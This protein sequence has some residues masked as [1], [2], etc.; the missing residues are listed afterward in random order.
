MK[1]S[2]PMKNIRKR[3]T[4]AM[5]AAA[6][7]LAM[8][9]NVPTGSSMPDAMLTA[10]AAVKTQ[11]E[12]YPGSNL[13]NQNYQKWSNPIDSYLTVSADGGFMRFQN[14][15]IDGKYLVEYYD[16]AYNI[17][18]VRKIDA[19]LPVFGGFYETETYYF[20]LTGQ[21]NPDELAET[22]CFRITKYDKDWNRLDS[23]GLYDCNTTIPFD[24]GS[25]RFAVCGN[26]LLIRTCHEMYADGNGLNHQANVTIQLD[27]DS[28]EITDSLTEVSNRNHGYISHSFNQF[29]HVEDGQI[30]SLDHGD[31]LPRSLALLEY[32]TDLSDGRFVPY[33]CNLI[34][35]VTFPETNG[36]HYN[37]TGASVGGFEISETSC[38]TAYSAENYTDNSVDEGT[39]NILIGVVDRETNA[40]TNVQLTA[41]EEGSASASTPH[42]VKI[43]G[44]R[45][46]VLWEREGNVYYTAV[47]AAG[48]PEEIHTI[49]GA[50]LSD[51]K[52]VVS[53]GK[54][55]WYT[56]CNKTTIF[57]EID[58]ADL[59]Q[60]TETV[61]ENGHRTEIISK[62]ENPGEECTVHCTQCGQDFTFAVPADITI[63]WSEK[64][65]YSSSTAMPQSYIGDTIAYEIEFEGG[66]PAF[67]DYDMII[68]D[69]E[70]MIAYPAGVNQ[71]E[72]SLLKEGRYTIS[73]VYPYCD[74]FNQT[75]TLA[76][77][78]YADHNVVK[79]P[80]EE[81]T[82]IAHMICQDCDYT[83]VFTVPSVI[84]LWIESSDGYLSSTPNARYCPY[85]DTTIGAYAVGQA[86]NCEMTIEFSDPDMAVFTPDLSYYFDIYGSIDWQKEGAVDVT[87]YPTYNPWVK[88]TFSLQIG[89]SYADGICTGCG[90]ECQHLSDNHTPANCQNANICGD[91]GM[92]FGEIDPDVHAGEEVIYLPNAEDAKLH[93]VYYACCRSLRAVEAHSFALDEVAGSYTCI[94]G[95]EAGT[96][97]DA[98][99]DGVADATDAAAILIYA[100]ADGAG[101]AAY[102]VSETDTESEALALLL[103]NVD[104]S[105]KTDAN[106][107]A[108]ILTYAA[109]IG[110]GEDADWETIIG[111]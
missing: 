17:Q 16:S 78:H 111:G 94:C 49:E 52:P 43:S 15:A 35:V 97:G 57:Y 102:L 3:L 61:I 26:Y 41:Y 83:G 98:N 54:L 90:A 100:A 55:V 107:A 72:L 92:T 25:A 36:L 22:E 108:F 33:Q 4:A 6:M 63:W 79:T 89:H 11:C 80:A 23:A 48:N 77:D 109:L 70:N 96:K 86:D 24:A 105:A 87:I 99:L 56:W 76:V 40:V 69:T 103:A 53:D 47:D 59:S 12:F 13:G 73:F 10:N 29:I 44:N 32:G 93:N 81:G 8:C 39:R 101:Q 46:A 64:G 7:A 1:G 106:D 66:D 68:S 2:V 28:M 50:V 62:A 75:F 95:A 85:A 91:C 14:G 45:F 110:S 37:Y 19:E 104:A 31:A 74:A 30:I 5:S 58:T 34:N 71:T 67:P 21:E 42:L 65:S 88:R 18:K 20:I 82:D 27:M 84:E 38:L 51:C 60:H 9:G